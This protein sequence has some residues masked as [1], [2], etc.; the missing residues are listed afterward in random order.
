MSGA[1]PAVPPLTL[2]IDLLVIG[3]VMGL[4]S[5]RVWTHKTVNPF[6]SEEVDRQL[7]FLLAGF[8]SLSICWCAVMA[9]ILALDLRSH[10]H[11]DLLRSILV[12][13][14]LATV[15][16]A[17]AAFVVAVGVMCLRKPSKLVP[18]HMRS[19]VPGERA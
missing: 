6:G 19:G 13:V 2:Q 7:G 8:P 17:L 3:A 4:V 5:Y 18:P 12:V 10:L 9:G 1:N 11:V 15:I 14:F 16:A